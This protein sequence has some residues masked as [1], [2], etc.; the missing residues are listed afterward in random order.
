MSSQRLTGKIA[1]VTGSSR[2]IG[3]AIAERLCREGASVAINYVNNA[4]S[5]KESA[6]EIKAAGGDAFA[7][8]A[9]V[10]KLERLGLVK[11]NTPLNIPNIVVT[12]DVSVAPGVKV[13]RLLQP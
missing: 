12:A 8:Q 2:G 9:D 7:L 1:L 5:A 10:S 6:T 4:N 11:G 3:R 13:A